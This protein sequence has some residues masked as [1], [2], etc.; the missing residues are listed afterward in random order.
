MAKLTALGLVVALG[1][2]VIGHAP[3]LAHGG[4][5][6]G[7]ATAPVAT[8]GAGLMTAETRGTYELLLRWGPVV[9]GE[10]FELE[11]FV[12][13]AVTNAPVAGELKLAMSGAASL[14]LEGK[15]LSPGQ[16]RLSGPAAT[17][18]R[19]TVT[20]TVRGSAG[21]DL[22]TTELTLASAAPAAPPVAV[23]DTNEGG[24]PLLWLVLALVLAVVLAALGYVAGRRASRAKGS[25]GAE[26]QTRLAA[27]AMVAAVAL[28]VIA[29]DGNAGAHGGEDHGAPAAPV[30]AAGNAVR[31]PKDVQFLLGVRTLGA[32]RRTLVERR[33][34]AGTVTLP[35]GARTT[36]VAP[37]T[38][39]LEAAPDGGFPRLGEA[40]SRGQVMAVLVELPIAADRA[41]LAAERARAAAQ[42]DGAASTLR[43]LR[44]DLQRKRSIRELV[45]AQELTD[46]EAAIGRADADLK[47]ARAAM[48]ALTLGGGA[49][50]LQLVAPIDGI[51]GTMSVTPGG[52]VEGGTVLFEIV[53]LARPW[54][55]A[56]VF[57]A[58][59]RRIDRTASA[60]VMGDDLPAEGVSA[61]PIAVSPTVD[62]VT[63]TV[64]VIYALDHT[65]GTTTA[66]AGNPVVRVNQFVRVDLPLGAGEEGSHDVLAVPVS[67]VVELDGVPSLW[68]KSRAEVFAAR[69]VA[70]GRREGGFVEVRGDI[71]QGALVVVEGAPF[72]RGAAPAGTAGEGDTAPGTGETR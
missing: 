16:Y 52:T 34:V 65:T 62:P 12:A 15:A 21:V 46:L 70:L 61:T 58:D 47:G 40:V 10:P 17:L 68:L 29:A 2:S 36:L 67:A 60:L 33:R 72:L 14:T 6:H 57:E 3:A 25:P 26:R 24:V 4:E 48:D 43:A 23:I 13:D 41:G 28:V 66:A 42:R 39:R 59:L 38:G 50:S 11:A 63:R 53:D 7:E 56:K 22:L 5:D 69:P 1:T 31:L 30:A 32:T 37:F 19:Y 71:G 49:T 54:V 51:V 45:A 9:A 55:A 18:G 44:L 35:P 64:D 27:T 20:A 8:G